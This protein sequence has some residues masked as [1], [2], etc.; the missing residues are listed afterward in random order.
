M[1]TSYRINMHSFIEFL[2]F[3][4]E[5]PGGIMIIAHKDPDTGKEQKLRRNNE[6]NLLKIA[7]INQNGVA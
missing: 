5:L 4:E 1:H 2:H 7:Q 3:R 6:R